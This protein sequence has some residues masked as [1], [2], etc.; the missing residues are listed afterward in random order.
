MNEFREHLKA[1]VLSPDRQCYWH[2]GEE[3]MIAFYEGELTA[4]QRE[5][6]QGHL[7][8]CAECLNLFR[9]VSDFFDPPREDEEQM[10]EAE[11]AGEWHQLWAKIKK[12]NV[13]LFPA[14]PA[15]KDKNSFPVLRLA[16]AA[17]LLLSFSS[18]GYLAWQVREEKRETEAARNEVA[19]IREE[20]Q[21]QA[22]QMDLAFR[23]LSQKNESLLAE[24]TAVVLRMAALNLALPPVPHNIQLEYFSFGEER[25]GA[26]KSLEFSSG[27]QTKL[28]VITIN[29][30]T[31][32]QN[33][34][35]EMQ[36]EAGRPVQAPAILKPVGDEN[37]LNMTI[38]RTGLKNGKYRL[39]LYGMKG[40][41]RQ[42][43]G[44]QGLT[45]KLNK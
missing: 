21:L 40:Q 11:I 45:I 22:S 7:A 12:D 9:N 13:I 19:K 8:E 26:G 18:T 42:K 30:P 28:L 32:F 44:E 5:A 1:A 27:V 43:L 37:T 17:S 2:I 31:N 4:A 6:M 10:S 14:R 16:V 20:Q 23:S 36:D 41:E 15:R 38:S 35:I 25:A 34:V 24:Q 29:N 39:T 33:Y 3:Q